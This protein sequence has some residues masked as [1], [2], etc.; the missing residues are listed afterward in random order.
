[1]VDRFGAAGLENEQ[2]QGTWRH[3][4]NT[5]RDTLSRLVVDMPDT[6]ANRK[7]MKAFKQ[8]WMT[9]LEQIDLWIISYRVTVE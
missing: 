7:W 8:R 9:K 6:P 1:M 2:V 3:A 4:G 5:Y